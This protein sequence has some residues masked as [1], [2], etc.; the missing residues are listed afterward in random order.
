MPGQ[1]IETVHPLLDPAIAPR[2]EAGR[3]ARMIE[4]APAGEGDHRA[5][6]HIGRGGIGIGDHRR[7]EIGFDHF[8]IR[9]RSGLGFR[10]SG[11]GGFSGRTEYYNSAAKLH[12]HFLNSLTSKLH[13]IWSCLMSALRLGFRRLQPA[14]P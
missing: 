8:G 10:G 4:F 7:G 13:T 12:A 5:R 14:V 9:Q 1:D 6:L 11:H 2:I 3:P